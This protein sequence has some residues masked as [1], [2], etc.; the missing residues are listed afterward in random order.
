MLLRR[1]SLI[2]VFR[3][4]NGHPGEWTEV[5]YAEWTFQEKLK[6]SNVWD[7]EGKRIPSE[8]G[9]EMGKDEL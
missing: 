1:H 7:E 4:L 9:E 6:R 8:E 5:E 3:S 2:V